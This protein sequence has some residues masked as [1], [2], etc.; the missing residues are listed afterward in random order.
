MQMNLFVSSF[1]FKMFV[2][3][4]GLAMALLTSPQSSNQP[5][6]SPAVLLP[7]DKTVGAA[8]GGQ[9]APQISQGSNGYLAVWLDARSSHEGDPL[10]SE[11]GI[12]IFG[13][14]LAVRLDISGNL[15]DTNPIALT[16]SRVLRS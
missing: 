14:I 16:H 12:P 3:L 1:P 2:L 11:I 10:H 15:L 9:S 13:D 5:Q 4:T 7:G 6:L 8:A